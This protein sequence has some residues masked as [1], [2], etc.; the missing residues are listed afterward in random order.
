MGSWKNFALPLVAAALLLGY[1]LWRAQQPAGADAPAA[2]PAPKVPARPQ[3]GGGASPERAEPAAGA[4]ASTAA[5]PVA[6]PATPPRKT[7]RDR[8]R[9]DALRLALRERARSHGGGRPPAPAEG[10]APQPAEL[11]KDYIQARI[12]DDLVP[13]ATEC[14]ESV[15]EDDPKLA[16]KMVMTFQ[17]VGDE[18]VGGVVDAAEV[19][20][21]S[22]L[23]NAAMDE[24]MRESMMSLSFEPPEGGGSVS[25]TYPF[26]FASTPE[27]ASR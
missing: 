24:C 22:T 26:V 16:G 2:A 7:E 3:P 12:K 1:Y 13:L 18:E 17:I 14:Y 9:S 15:L 4:T 21:S 8:A 20:P 5:A 10:D 23:R 25:V 6:S 27:Q 11:D 19:D